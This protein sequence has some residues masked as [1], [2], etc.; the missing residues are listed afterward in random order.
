MRA[1][2]PRTDSVRRIAVRPPNWSTPGRPVRLFGCSTGPQSA[3]NWQPLPTSLE[4]FV[5]ESTISTPY[6]LL[7]RQALASAEQ[8]FDTRHLLRMVEELDRI[9]IAARQDGGLRDQ[10]LLLHAMPHSVINGAGLSAPAGESL[11]ESAGDVLSEV[12]EVIETLGRWI[13]PL[14]VLQRL[15]VSDDF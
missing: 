2:R 4:Q 13:A 10:L 6:G 15:A 7:D 12:V 14:E 8:F 1:Q 11:P 3:S 9:S 5:S